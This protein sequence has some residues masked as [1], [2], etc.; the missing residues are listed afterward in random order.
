MR[1]R[2]A[3]PTTSSQAT[4]HQD[5]ASRSRLA[6]V[7][8]RHPV[9]S[10]AVLA[11]AGFWTLLAVIAGTAAVSGWDDTGLPSWLRMLATILGSWMPGLAGLVVVAASG[12]RGAVTALA[13]MFVRIDVPARWF[14]AAALPLGLALVA[15][16]VLRIAG[17]SP[18][19][20]SSPSPVFWL[21]LFTV[22]L[23][24]GPAGEEA[25]WRGVMLPHLLRRHQPAIAAVL[26][27]LL[28]GLWHA[29][30]WIASGYEASALIRYIGAFLVAIV[31]L[32]VLMTWIY[33][34]T[35][36]SLLPMVVAH[37][38]F[39]AGLALAGPAGFNLA[40]S[41]PLFEA[42]AGALTTVA[43]LVWLAGGLDKG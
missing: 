15:G 11:Y 18:S 33:R 38:A 37:F 31:A 26:M 40:P 22:T 25:G 3:A 43:A 29:P 35:P 21:Q 28:W 19:D 36:H 42:L 2:A 1:N 30:L 6:S 17:I 23:V 13:G 5:A 39:N 9:T 7:I 16:G 10:F 12:G 41:L 27:G 32:S 4:L 8:S 24:S 14:I 34:R 20:P